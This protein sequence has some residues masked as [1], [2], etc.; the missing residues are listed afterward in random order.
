MNLSRQK[1]IG[2]WCLISLILYCVAPAQD[3]WGAV[4]KS[5]GYY[6]TFQESGM[7][8]SGDY[9]YERSSGGGVY[10]PDL[11]RWAATGAIWPYEYQDGG[12]SRLQR[13]MQPVDYVLRPLTPGETLAI[14]GP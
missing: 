8:A 4:E 10:G 13:F 2:V 14:Q 5:V 12:L 9:D 11:D 6:P 1:A 7:L 3:Q